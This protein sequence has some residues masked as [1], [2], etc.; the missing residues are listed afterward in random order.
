MAS[1]I[2]TLSGGAE[3]AQTQEPPSGAA[4]PGIEEV[5][6]GAAAAPEGASG[7]DGQRGED[8]SAKL[9]GME[10]RLHKAEIEAKAARAAQSK[11]DTE[12]AQE[13]RLAAAKE[14]WAWEQRSQDEEAQIDRLLDEGRVAE[15][16]ELKASVKARAKAEERR[17]QEY[18]A[19]Q[20]SQEQTFHGE[21]AAAIQRAFPNASED[22]YRDALN[23]ATLSAHKEGR[24]A[25]YADVFAELQTQTLSAKEQELT[26]LREQTKSLE[27]RMKALENGEVG[28][29]VRSAGGPD[30]VQGGLST[31]NDHQKRLDRLSLG[32]DSDG[33][34]PT[35]EDKAWLAAKE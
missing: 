7:D 16:Q 32:M 13:R 8:V 15:A 5:P 4:V 34:S 27:E 22:E 25:R 12:L 35:A 9:L 31:S 10:S 6:A 26:T 2:A 28:V 30:R 1:E 19:W 18:A 14:Q 17:R 21:F 33:N 20:Q 23:A 29:R 3:D 24:A 11:A